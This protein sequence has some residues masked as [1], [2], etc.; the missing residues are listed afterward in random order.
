M[1]DKLK[2]NVIATVAENASF[3]AVIGEEFVRNTIENG[4]DSET[5]DSIALSITNDERAVASMVER[6][7]IDM[8]ST[9]MATEMWKKPEK[10]KEI[11]ENLTSSWSYETFE[12]Y[13]RGLDLGLVDDNP[14][15]M[16][17]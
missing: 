11:V 7:K 3:D 5:I 15:G 12:N 16:K 17:P 9:H 4:W 14:S 2:E 8:I 1:A 13:A 6:D 10:A